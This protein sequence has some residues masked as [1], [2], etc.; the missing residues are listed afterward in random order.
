MPELQRANCRTGFITSDTTG[1]TDAPCAATASGSAACHAAGTE[2]RSATAI[3]Y[4]HAVTEERNANVG[5]DPC[6]GRSARSGRVGRP[7]HR[8]IS[9]RQ[10]QGSTESAYSPRTATLERVS[11]AHNISAQAEGSSRDDRSS[12]SDD[13]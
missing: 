1:T 4:W 5:L 3:F 7:W 2:K 8:W 9:L 11:G 6:R 12:D 13:P 10:V